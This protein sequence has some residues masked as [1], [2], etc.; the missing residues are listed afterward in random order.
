[1]NNRTAVSCVIPAFNEARWIAP[2]LALVADH[3]LI[4]QVIVVDD[5]SDDETGEVAQKIASES[6]KVS[7][8]RHSKNL[9]KTKAVV[10][11]IEAATNEYLLLLDGDLVGLKAANLT[12]LVTPVIA[13][14]ADASVSLIGDTPLFRRIIG[15]DYISGQRVMRR[16][17]LAEH[18]DTLRELPRFGLEVFINKLWLEQDFRIAVVR[19]PGVANPAKKTKWGR[20]ILPEIT[21]SKD[22]LKVVPLHRILPQI[23][24]L[25][26]HRV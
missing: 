8:I 24:A 2:V 11:G 25:R 9:G 10:T 12:D 14:R 16:E 5:A 4:S 6:P 22:I 17:L 13:G 26:A 19:W 21:M 18:T 3:P 1:L 7:V 23:L 20:G 15:V